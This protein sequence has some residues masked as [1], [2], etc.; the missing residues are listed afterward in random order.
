[1]LR[2]YRSCRPAWTS[3][4]ARATLFFSAGADLPFGV[5]PI[6]V[7]ESDLA[8]VLLDFTA[9]PHLLAF[10]DVEHGKTTLLT[11]LAS[12]LV[13]IDSR[14]GQSSSSTIAA[15]CSAAYPTSHRA[16]YASSA[17]SAGLLW[18]LEPRW[19]GDCRRRT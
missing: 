18:R 9:R 5:V 3:S 14:G 19:R 12:G 7:G 4:A 13:A 8:P 17:S 2:R 15:R 1:M 10:A 16:G 11:T 6:G